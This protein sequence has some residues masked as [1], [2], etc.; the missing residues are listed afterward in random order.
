MRRMTNQSRSHAR[1]FGPQKFAAL[2]ATFAGALYIFGSSTAVM[3]TCVFESCSSVSTGPG[4]QSK[5]GAIHVHGSTM[6]LSDCNFV[7][8]TA[9]SYGRRSEAVACLHDSSP[10]LCALR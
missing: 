5:G 3:N 9:T 7:D 2:G 4:T 10:A 6:E 1:P 8:C